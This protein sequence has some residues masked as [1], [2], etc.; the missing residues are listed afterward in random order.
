MSSLPC[1][2]LFF[3][4][5]EIRRSL[6]GFDDS[7]AQLSVAIKVQ[8]QGNSTKSTHLIIPYL[9]RFGSISGES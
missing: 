4:L 3:K 5:P 6:A 1:F 9:V 7:D 2:V 8:Q